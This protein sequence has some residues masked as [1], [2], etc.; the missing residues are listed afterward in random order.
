MPH[1]LY[2]LKLLR[3]NI[4]EVLAYLLTCCCHSR[5]RVAYTAVQV[6]SASY[7]SEA[8]AHHVRPAMNATYLAAAAG[9]GAR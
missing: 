1:V 2:K 5:H 3:I 6:N 4:A 9:P 7:C 8:E